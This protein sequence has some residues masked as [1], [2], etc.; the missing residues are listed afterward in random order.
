[1]SPYGLTQP[2]L[3]KR[4]EDSEYTANRKSSESANQLIGSARRELTRL[5]G[6]KGTR[7][8]GTWPGV[9]AVKQTEY[10]IPDRLHDPEQA[11]TEPDANSVDDFKRNL[12]RLK[13]FD[14]ERFRNLHLIRHYE[15]RVRPEN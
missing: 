1:M 9:N 13:L 4:I 6:W 7:W 14:F 15:V 2:S 11:Q 5:A 12:D 8:A 10:A 3:E